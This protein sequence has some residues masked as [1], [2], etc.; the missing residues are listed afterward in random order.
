MA[1]YAEHL[2]RHKLRFAALLLIPIA[3]GISVTVVF[4]S[5]RAAATLKIEDPSAFGAT[6]QPVGWSQSQ[7]PAQNLAESVSQVVKTPA[8]SDSLSSRLASS[9]AADPK[10]TVASVRTNLKVTASSSH[11]IT[12]TYTCAHAALCQSVMSDAID[13]VHEQLAKIQQ[14]Q[15]AAAKGF[16]S[17]QLKDAQANLAAAQTALKTYA[18]ANPAATI[19]ASSNDPRVVQLVNL[20][21]LWRA[22]VLEAQN[23]L[24]QAEYLETASVRFLQ[25]GTTVVDPSHVTGSRFVGDGTSVLPGVAVLLVG[26]ALVGLYFVLLAWADRTAADAKALERSLGVPVVAQ[27]PK[28]VG[29]RGV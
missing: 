6:F 4:A 29:S 15:A 22:K 18:A 1:K 2:F 12:L 9:G 7:T 20:V 10:Q 21:Q 17:S 3:L 24:S 16:W 25:V 13:S 27:I 26:V 14:D 8:F 28:L 5:Y 19:D 11:S 23:S